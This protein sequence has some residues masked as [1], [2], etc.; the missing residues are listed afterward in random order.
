MKTLTSQRGLSSIGWLVVIFLFGFSVLIFSK[1]VPHYLDDRYVI[2]TLKTLAEDPTFPSMTVNE[3]KDKLRKIF[4]INGIRGKP[5]KSTKVTRI[6]TGTLITTEYE[7][8]F[9]L[10]YNIDIVLVFKHQLDSANPNLC[11]ESLQD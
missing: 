2:A 5:V 7:E 1:L 9:N 4:V 10:F 11:C 8:R 3:V 6:S